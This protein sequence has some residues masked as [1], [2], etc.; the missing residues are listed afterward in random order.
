MSLTAEAL[1]ELHHLHQRIADLR[2]R[3]E[4]GPKQIQA[5]QAN[6]ARIEEELTQAK[7][8][9]K[10]ELRRASIATKNKRRPH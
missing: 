10:R 3:L 6:V 9:V 2:N 7:E 4:R 5:G 8:T 1:R